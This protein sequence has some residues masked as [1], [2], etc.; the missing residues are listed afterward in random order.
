L[1]QLFANIYF[2]ETLTLDNIVAEDETTQAGTR[3][4]AK[5]NCVINGIKS[6]SRRRGY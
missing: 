5:G 4:R 3:I 2:E 6:F 1:L